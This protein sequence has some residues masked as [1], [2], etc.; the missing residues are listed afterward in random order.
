MGGLWDTGPGHGAFLAFEGGGDMVSAMNFPLPGSTES[1]KEPYR[2]SPELEQYV[3]RMWQPS[4]QTF[5]SGYLSESALESRG[6][7]LPQNNTTSIYDAPEQ[8]STRLHLSAAQPSPDLLPSTSKM[9]HSSQPLPSTGCTAA[10]NDMATDYIAT[11]SLNQHAA[12]GSSNNPQ[13]T[14]ADST[15]DMERSTALSAPPDTPNPNLQGEDLE[16]RFESVLRA[17]EKAGFESVDDMLTQYYTA[18]FKEDSVPYWTQMRSR[19]RSLP[20]FLASLQESTKY[21]TDRDAQGYRQQIMHS[22]E[23]VH[24]SELSS[25]TD[26]AV[27][28]EERRKRINEKASTTYG[29]LWKAIAELDKS[30][31]IKRKKTSI[32]ANVSSVSSFNT[33]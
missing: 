24:L 32:R 16:T 2:T 3:T 25:A 5:G 30:P 19:S 9:H 12:D 26:K 15:L 27:Q 17:V 7:F 14:E 4:F 33:I 13:P 20:A 22:A 29:I 28:D 23:N 6:G 10:A 21:W 18:I 31:D 11:R 8:Q 1:I